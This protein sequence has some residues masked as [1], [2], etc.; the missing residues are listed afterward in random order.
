MQPDPAVDRFLADLTDPARQSAMRDL[1]SIARTRLPDG[2]Q[3]VLSGAMPSWVVPLSTFPAGYHCTPGEPLPFL[4]IAS[5]KRHIAVYHMGIYSDPDLLAWFQVSHAEQVPTKLNM[6]KSCIRYTNP[7][8]IPFD[9]IGELFS[10]MSPADWVAR[11][12]AR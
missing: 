2:F 11:Y 5:Q 8:K 7:K 4:S 1:V 12:E 10:R 3:E 6:G 9:L